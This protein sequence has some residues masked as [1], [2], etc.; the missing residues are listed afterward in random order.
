MDAKTQKAE[1]TRAAVASGG[2]FYT[3]MSAATLLADL[4]KPQKVPL[5]TDPPIPLWNTWPVLVLFLMVIGAEWVLRKR[6]Q[7]V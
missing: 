2:K 4:P 5:D 1:L 7:M 6:K 3:P